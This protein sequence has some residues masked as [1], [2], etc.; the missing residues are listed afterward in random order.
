MELFHEEMTILRGV[1]WHK[2]C[3]HKSNTFTWTTLQRKELTNDRFRRMGYKRPS[4]CK[5]CISGE[6]DVNHLFLSCPYTQECWT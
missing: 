3:L 2:L 5:L 4:R 1:C 6:E